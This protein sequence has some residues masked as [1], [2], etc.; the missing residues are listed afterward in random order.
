VIGPVIGAAVAV[1]MGLGH[2]SLEYENEQRRA[3]LKELDR[4]RSE[5]AVA[6]HTRGVLEERKRLAREIHDTVTQGLASIVILLGATGEELRRDKHHRGAQPHRSSP[7][8]P[9]A[10]L[11]EARRFVRAL[12]ARRPRRH[13][14]RR[15]P[16]TAGRRFGAAVSPGVT[17]LGIR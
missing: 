16:R 12:G 10:N 9:R 7:G 5:L 3:L 6:E 17:A 13:D 14:P 1:A 8:Y 15:L 4:T 11:D 2:R